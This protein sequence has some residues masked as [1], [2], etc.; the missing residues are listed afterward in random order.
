MNVTLEAVSQAGRCAAWL[1][2]LAGDEARVRVVT[3]SGAVTLSSK[4]LQLFSPLVRETIAS[5]PT[6][7][8]V[9]II[10]PDTEASTVKHLANFLSKG[11]IAANELCALSSSEE[12][13][14]F[15]DVL[16]KN[17]F[18]L[19]RCLQ[20]DIKQLNLSYLLLP[21]HPTN[22][23]PCN[24]D[25]ISKGGK[26]KLR[27]MDELLKPEISQDDPMTEVENIVDKTDENDALNININN[28][29]LTNE[30]EDLIEDIDVLEP[31][32][33]IDIVEEDVPEDVESPSSSS[34]GQGRQGDGAAKKLRLRGFSRPA[35]ANILPPPLHTRGP[36]VILCG[37]CNSVF[38]ARNN[39][40]F[41][42]HLAE[43]HFKSYLSQQLGYVPGKPVLKCPEPDCEFK[44]VQGKP[45]MTRMFRHYGVVHNKVR[46]AIGSQIVGRYVPESEMLNET[47]P[48]QQQEDGGAGS[49]AQHDHQYIAT[50]TS[51]ESAA[52]QPMVQVNRK[53]NGEESPS[54]SLEGTRTPRELQPQVP[55]QCSDSP[56]S[57]MAGQKT[58]CVKTRSLGST[59]VTRKDGKLVVKGPDQVAV[60]EVAAQLAS[61]Q[62]KLGSVGGEQVLIIVSDGLDLK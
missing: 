29:N 50:T 53:A 61:G 59:I 27:Q 62:A 40:E 39:S 52:A 9:V 24:D 8:P 20:L 10:I 22:S 26:L 57:T 11:Q 23:S 14:E 37:Y 12:Q 13:A 28:N 4:L 19:A 16:Q 48:G 60:K 41:Y 33:D 34:H 49:G 17:I 44:H 18:S 46:E 55:S 36:F 43:T 5:V 1:E 47:N 2:A 51:Q 58:V 6:Q 56:N 31:H 25:D 21:N 35:D 30:R 15:F 32:I 3:S 45:N 42:R 7:E 38:K 54:N